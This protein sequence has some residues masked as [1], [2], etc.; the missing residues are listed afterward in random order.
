MKKK[1]CLA[2]FSFL[3]K[4]KT[5]GV[6]EREFLKFYYITHRLILFLSDCNGIRTHNHLVRCSFTNYLVVGSNPVAVT[7]L[8]D[9]APGSIKE[10]LDIH[11]TTKCRYACV[12]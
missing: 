3:K 2:C 10:F 5:H 12:T 1:N 9:I 8:S 4:K 11:E 7:L 6:V